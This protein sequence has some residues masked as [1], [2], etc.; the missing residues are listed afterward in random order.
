MLSYFS[1]T[2]SFLRVGAFV[3]VH[4]GM[5]LVVYS[6]APESG[7]ARVIVLVLG[8]ALIMGI[9]GV[10]TYIQMLRL[11]FY[12]M[13]SRFYQGDGKP[14]HPFRLQPAEQKTAETAE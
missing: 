12:E 4:A 6:L 7:A 3:L 5:M 9:E 14:F 11:G 8:N 10:L 1:N 13:F 2:V